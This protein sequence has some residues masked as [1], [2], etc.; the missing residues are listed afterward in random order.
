LSSGQTQCGERPDR[1]AGLGFTSSRGLR[2]GRHERIQISHPE[3]LQWGEIEHRLAEGTE[4]VAKLP[5]RYEI[6]GLFTCGDRE[7]ETVRDTVD[8]KPSIIGELN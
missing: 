2:Q 8:K 6:I 7:L 4:V 5:L 1:I 3:K